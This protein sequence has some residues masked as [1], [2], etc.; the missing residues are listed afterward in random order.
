MGPSKYRAA[1]AKGFAKGLAAERKAAQKGGR[2][3]RCNLF[4]VTWFF[5]KNILNR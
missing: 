3:F 2:C 4:E 5:E 1:G